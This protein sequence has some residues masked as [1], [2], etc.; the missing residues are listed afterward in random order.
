[1]SITP[2]KSNP[3]IGSKTN[4]IEIF[5]DDDGTVTF[6]DLPT[7]LKA[8]ADLLAGISL[9]LLPHEP[10]RQSPEWPDLQD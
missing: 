8:V 1:M 7:E 9:P 5:V 10:D 3:T 2:D 6:T 4:S